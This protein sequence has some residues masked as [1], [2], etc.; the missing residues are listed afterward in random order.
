MSVCLCDTNTERDIHINDT[1]V[2][3]GL[4]IFSPDSLEDQISFDNYSLEP[5]PQ[6]VSRTSNV[7][8]HRFCKDAKLSSHTH[9]YLWSVCNKSLLNGNNVHVLGAGFSACGPHITVAIIHHGMIL[10]H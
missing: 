4:A 6:G 9:C 2:S 8:I 10:S 5:L 7:G 1:L 3:Q